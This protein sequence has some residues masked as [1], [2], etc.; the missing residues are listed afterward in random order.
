MDRKIL[1]AKKDKM[2]T[3]GSTYG[4]E[5]ALEVGLDGSDYYEITKEEYDAIFAVAVPEEV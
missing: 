2:L 4:T 3:N 5:I 1:Y